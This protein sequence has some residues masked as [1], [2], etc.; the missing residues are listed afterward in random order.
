MD[1]QIKFENGSMVVHLEEFLDARNITNVRKLLKIIRRSYTPECEQQIR[2]FI[3]NG[4]EEL[5][6]KQ[7]EIRRYVIGYEQKI[8]YC[9]GQLEYVLHVRDSYK[10]STPLYRSEEWGK[11]NEKVKVA[12]GELAEL[13]KSL[14]SYE[15]G[16]NRNIKNRGFYKKVLENIE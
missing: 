14:R 10:K 5:D 6:E 1:L 8:R 9:Q 2:E 15:S 12:K 13:K 7:A 4:F 11:W 16:Y 3:E